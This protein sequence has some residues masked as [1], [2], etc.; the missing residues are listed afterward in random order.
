MILPSDFNRNLVFSS[1][2]QFAMCKPCMKC[3][4]TGATQ[5]PSR[6]HNTTLSLDERKCDECVGRGFHQQFLSFDQLV[7]LVAPTLFER[8]IEKLPEIIGKAQIAVIESVMNS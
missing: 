1:E 3:H 5:D 2:T 6:Q 4:G 8:F 7:E